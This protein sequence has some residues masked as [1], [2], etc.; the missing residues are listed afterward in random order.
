MTRG[1]GDPPI[2]PFNPFYDRRYGECVHGNGM[3]VCPEC[4]GGTEK[5]TKLLR[6]LEEEMNPI[7][8]NKC[9]CKPNDPCYFHKITVVGVSGSVITLKPTPLKNTGFEDIDLFLD[10]CFKTMREKG[11][12]YRE[13]N[14][15]D[16]LHNFRTVGEDMDLPP[17]KVWYI[18]AS[19]HWKAIK[20]F[21]KEEGQSESEPIEGRIKDM[22]VYLLLLYRRAQEMK[23]KPE[24]STGPVYLY[25]PQNVE[26]VIHSASFVEEMKSPV[27][28]NGSINLQTTGYIVK[29]QTVSIPVDGG[30]NV[31]ADVERLQKLAG[32]EGYGVV[33][34]PEVAEK[35]AEIFRK[36][37]ERDQLTA[38]EKN[39]VGFASRS[40]KQQLNPEIDKYACG[41]AVVDRWEWN[42]TIHGKQPWKLPPTPEAFNKDYDFRNDPAFKDVMKIAKEAEEYVVKAF[43]KKIE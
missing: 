18:Y 26:P 29:K 34:A 14:D 35:S 2:R 1:W 42:C 17:E 37:E 39:G 10:D 40:H 41:C 43:P 19:K 36:M 8:N 28:K 9:T 12:D 33:V 13:G 38:D 24:R 6:K 15:T 32:V 30:G 5:F 22:I 31:V 27:E 23:K 3:A 4:R 20:T 16:L 7:E 21:I 25:A 11:H